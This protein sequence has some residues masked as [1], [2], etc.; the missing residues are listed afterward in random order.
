MKQLFLYILTT[1]YSKVPGEVFSSAHDLALLEGD[2]DKQII[3]AALNYIYISS[4][5]MSII[6]SE[7]N[8]K[9]EVLA[10]TQDAKGYFSPMKSIFLRRGTDNTS[11]TTSLLSLPINTTII[12]TASTWTITFLH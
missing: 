8:S 2:G 9:P 10:A 4:I 12:P 1:L 7:V 5:K 6:T 3:A 11:L